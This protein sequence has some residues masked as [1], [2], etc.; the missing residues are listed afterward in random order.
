MSGGDMRSI[1]ALAKE[2]KLPGLRGYLGT[3]SGVFLEYDSTTGK[4]NVIYRPSNPGGGG[5]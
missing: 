3:P 4:T 2:R 5:L 1:D